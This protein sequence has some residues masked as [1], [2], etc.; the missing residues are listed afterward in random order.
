MSKDDDLLARI[1]ALVE[2]N[3]ATD[4]LPVGTERGFDFSLVDTGTVK[5]VAEAVEAVARH[6]VYSTVDVDNTGYHTATKRKDDPSKYVDND[7]L[8]A[9]DSNLYLH[10]TT[11]SVVFTDENGTQYAIRTKTDRPATVRQKDRSVM[12][13]VLPPKI[14]F[15]TGGITGGEIKISARNSTRSTDTGIYFVYGDGFRVDPTFND[16]R[17]THAIPNRLDL[18]LRRPIPLTAVPYQK[19]VTDALSGLR[20]IVD[21]QP[22]AVRDARRRGRWSSPASVGMR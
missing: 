13:F 1:G 9:D 8:I 2:S 22:F 14:E 3:G 18:L 6:V 10:E 19:I 20:G 7:S 4:R 12:G 16:N 15:E 21:R 5:F 11:S 17:G